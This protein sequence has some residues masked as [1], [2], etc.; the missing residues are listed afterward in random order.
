[1]KKVIIINRIVFFLYLKYVFFFQFSTLKSKSTLK[2]TY[3]HADQN[4]KN[5][6]LLKISRTF[7]LHNNDSEISLIYF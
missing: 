2:G 7:I 5:S 4:A 1:M 3:F 6:T